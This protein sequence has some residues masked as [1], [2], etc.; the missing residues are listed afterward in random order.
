MSYIQVHHVLINLFTNNNTLE[1]INH[2]MQDTQP[3]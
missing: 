1:G 2:Q 3:S